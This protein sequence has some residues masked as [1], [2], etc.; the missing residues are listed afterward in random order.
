MENPSASPPREAKTMEINPVETKS[1]MVETAKE[2]LSR[3]L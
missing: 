2:A 1:F 3:T